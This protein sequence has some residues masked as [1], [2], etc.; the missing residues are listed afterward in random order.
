MTCIDQQVKIGNVGGGGATGHKAERCA[1]A[2][3]GYTKNCSFAALSYPPRAIL[4]KIANT[5]ASSSAQIATSIVK[6]IAEAGAS[7]LAGRMLGAVLRVLTGGR[8]G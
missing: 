7:K 2:T 4:D 6:P 3:L 1:Q 8:I 5:A